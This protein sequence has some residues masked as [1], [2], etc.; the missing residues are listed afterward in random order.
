MKKLC[1]SAFVAFWSSIVTLLAV[2][3]LATGEPIK[4]TKIVSL[5]ELA[6]HA[7]RDD[8]WLAID[9]KVYDLTAYLPRHPA[10]PTILLAWC[11]REASEAMHTKGYGRDHSPAAWQLLD[12]F[13]IGVLAEPSP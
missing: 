7:D 6:A 11:G 1:Y 12:G 3:A 5:S 8:C 2:H 13:L 9:G 10:P 4:S